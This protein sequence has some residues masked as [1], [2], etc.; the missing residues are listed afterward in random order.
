M[1]P[2]SVLLFSGAQTLVDQ[3]IP[4]FGWAINGEWQ[5]TAAEPRLNMFGESGSYLGIT[6]PRPVLP[7]WRSRSTPTRSAC[8]PTRW[9]SLRCATG[10]KNSFDKYGTAA[11]PRWSS[12]TSAP[13]GI[14]DLSVRSR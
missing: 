2:V 4:T 1:L 12:T 11:T 3:N 6:N 9:P 10:V 14:A 13:F 7:W 8:W 5:G